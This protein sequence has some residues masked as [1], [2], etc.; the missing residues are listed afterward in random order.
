MA[1]LQQAAGSLILRDGKVVGQTLIGQSLI[2]PKYFLGRPSATAPVAQN[3]S[4]SSGSILGPLNPALADAVKGHIEALR[5]AEPGNAGPMPIELVTT[6]G[7]GLD[8]HISVAAA[9]YQATRIA[10]RRALPQARVR[11]LIDTHSEGMLLGLIGER[12][13]NLL[14]LNLALDATV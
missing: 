5:A 9:V 1:F 13:I 14:R 10:T 12:R 3:A 11:A 8:P 2:D 6:S 7:S 4:A